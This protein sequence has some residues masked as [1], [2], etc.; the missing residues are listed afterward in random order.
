MDPI[1]ASRAQRQHLTRVVHGFKQHLDREAE[2][3]AVRR[4]NAAVAAYWQSL[5]DQTRALSIADAEAL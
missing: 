4:L 2:A 1:D 5:D 3:M